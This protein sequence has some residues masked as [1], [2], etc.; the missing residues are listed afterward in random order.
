MNELGFRI[1]QY[2]HIWCQHSLRVG[3]ASAHTKDTNDHCDLGFD[4]TSAHTKLDIE[5]TSLNDKTQEM[6]LEFGHTKDVKVESLIIESQEDQHYTHKQPWNL[7]DETWNHT[8][9]WQW[10]LNHDVWKWRTITPSKVLTSCKEN[11][12]II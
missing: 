1:W 3:T 7:S 9:K 6:A 12:K 5:A 2:T 11:T 4:T 10:M 8:N